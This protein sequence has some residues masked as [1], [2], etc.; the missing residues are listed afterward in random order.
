MTRLFLRFS[1]SAV[2]V[3]SL[4][5][6]TV[7]G[8]DIAPTDRRVTFE[9]I[10]RPSPVERAD[11]LPPRVAREF[12]GVWVSPLD[13][14]TGA[15][16]PSRMGMSPDDQRAQLRILLDHARSIGL[17]AIVLHIRTEGDALY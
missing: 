8:G 5:G 12:R 11:S 6:G 13:A 17:N 3:A 7:H 1:I 4:S 10:V 2:A 14:M 9:R 16:W 15:D